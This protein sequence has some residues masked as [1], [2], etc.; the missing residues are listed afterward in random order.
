VLKTRDSIFVIFTVG[1]I[2]IHLFKKKFGG[3]K[4]MHKHCMTDGID[5]NTDFILI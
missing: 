2:Q 5:K 1:A 3:L 4:Y